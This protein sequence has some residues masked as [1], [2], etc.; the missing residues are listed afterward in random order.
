MLSSP[1]AYKVTLKGSLFTLTSSSSLRANP[2]PVLLGDGGAILV[3]ASLLNA[4]F[5]VSHNVIVS[6][7]ISIVS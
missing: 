4:P 6:V 5:S 7:L 1:Q 2:T 3:L